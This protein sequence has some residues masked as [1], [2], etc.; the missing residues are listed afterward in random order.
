MLNMKKKS[1]LFFLVLLIFSIFA[2]IYSSTIS[3]SMASEDAAVEGNGLN[4]K[5]DY[6]LLELL[7]DNKSYNILEKSFGN[8]E[9]NEKKADAEDD[10]EKIYD[11]DD[12]KSSG[13]FSDD[14]VSNPEGGNDNEGRINEYS[15][16]IGMALRSARMARANETQVNVNITD[17]DIVEAKSE[18]S[19]PLKQ[20]I[21]WKS[22][23]LKM[24]WEIT[25]DLKNLKRGDFFEVDL[26]D[27]LKFPGETAATRFDLMTPD[28]NELVAKA[29]VSP[30]NTGGG[31]IR[32][33]FTEYVESEVGKKDLKGI[34][35]LACTVSRK[36]LKEEYNNQISITIDGKTKTIT[37]DGIK[38][39][40]DEILSKWSERVAN[41]P[42]NRI[43]EW[44]MRINH[45]KGALKEA[46]ISDTLEVEKGD[47][48]IISFVPESFRLLVVKFDEYG[49]TVKV[50]KD[51][52]ISSYVNLYD[53]NSSFFLDLE[54]VWNRE[55]K[56][57]RLTDDEGRLIDSL[58]NRQVM[59]RYRSN[60]I[61]GFKLRNKAKLYA[62]GRYNES[63]SGFEIS[64]SGGEGSASTIGK[65]KIRKV[66]KDNVTKALKGARFRIRSKNNGKIFTLETD[67][68]GE[69]ISEVLDPGRYIIEE[70]VPP[71]G[72]IKNNQ[73][74]TYEVKG[75]QVN[76]L[77]IKNERKRISIPVEK[78]WL[79]Y[80]G[81]S[82]PNEKTKG[83]PAISITLKRKINNVED[84][85]FSLVRSLK[86]NEDPNLSWKYVFD[87]LE[88]QN[89]NGD[90]YTYYI[91]EDKNALTGD[92]EFNKYDKQSYTGK[93]NDTGLINETLRVYNKEKRKLFEL[94]V[95]KL[96]QSASGQPINHDDLPVIE[97]KLYRKSISSP[98]E[99]VKVNDKDS[100]TLYRDASGH[101]KYVY[102]NLDIKDPA[103]NFYTYE[104]REIVPR[105]FTEVSE[106]SERTLV[107]KEGTNLSTV[108]LKLKNKVNPEYPATGGI[109][110]IAV[111]ATGLLMAC[112]GRL[113]KSLTDS[114]N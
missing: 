70:V 109:G 101:W 32:V 34:M 38:K 102:K 106:E 99:A 76:L 1:K 5:G 30:R 42:E 56:P 103:G 110:S 12:S 92:F 44:A 14:K 50:Y 45:K 94:P 60:Y 79:D 66:D 93:N 77:T 95:E 52:N 54:E 35:Y 48:S 65:L 18:S 31:K 67:S 51:V 13:T 41:D 10:N 7:G 57:L 3:Y 16:N 71:Q 33:T 53:F 82:I 97:I 114:S 88:L 80:N 6:G 87:K 63:S 73:A 81:S 24:K 96:W 59:I 43:T 112:F 83:Y 21:W 105:G 39:L 4:I 2:N 49:N 29:V 78:I 111:V 68:K 113:F 100:V 20:L 61:P 89:D 11:K 25:G 86:Y 8:N 69:A 64:F 107:I 27:G 62:N 47:P 17:F 37:S 85:A 15:D 104:V 98:E 36:Y 108:G 9:N 46:F 19:K 75:D 91:E 23:Y 90:Y 55:I 22:Y 74:Y 26:P 72:Y 84:N 28:G 58:D 40:G